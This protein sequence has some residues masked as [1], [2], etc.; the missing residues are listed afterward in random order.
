MRTQDI[1]IGKYY[2]HKDTPK[3]GWAK[4]IKILKPNQEENKGNSF[5]VVKCEWSVGWND[6]FGMIKYFRPRDLFKES[7]K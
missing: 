3:Y 4:V 6:L 7:S 5:I 2:R 1:Y